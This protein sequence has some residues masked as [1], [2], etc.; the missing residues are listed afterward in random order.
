MSPLD[1]VIE[2]VDPI[3]V[4]ARRLARAGEDA[5]FDHT[6]M[7]LGTADA[8]GRVSV[9]IVLLHG[10]DARG[11]VFFTNYESRKSRDI[12][13]NPQ[14]ALS[15]YWPWVDE[16]VR[17]EGRLAPIDAAESD[18]YFATRPRGKQIGAWASAQSR[19]QAT[20]ADLEARCA[21]VARRFDGQ[22]V[23]RPPFWGGFRL[24][25]D[26]V[27]FWTAGESRLHD[28]VLYTRDGDAWRPSR[29]D[30]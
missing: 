10:L 7:A 11:L 22:P 18:A 6:A 12:A 15:F 24:R 23:P 26:R 21:E 5:P 4:F 20:R 29:L 8:G 13:A 3:N 25:P 16:Q 19:P 9:R 30:P 28:R 2:P 17:F 1:T 14:A 27:E